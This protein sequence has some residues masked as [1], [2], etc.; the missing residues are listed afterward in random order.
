MEEYGGRDSA[1]LRDRLD[2]VRDIL[3]R[4]KFGFPPQR[5]KITAGPRAGKTAVQTSAG[6][7]IG[8]DLLPGKSLR[9]EARVV[10]PER[11]GRIPLAGDRLDC[12]VFS[13]FPFRMTCDGREILAC[14][15]PPIIRGRILAAVLDDLTPGQAHLVSVTIDVPDT[16]VAYGF[17]LAFS[18][19]RLRERWHEGDRAWARLLLASQSPSARGPVLDALAGRADEIFSATV[20]T[21]PDLISSLLP[22]RDHEPAQPF[23]VVHL[24]GHA[25]L[26]V[27]WLWSWDQAQRAALAVCSRAVDLLERAP[28]L[29]FSFSQPAV[30]AM[31]GEQDP[32]LLEAVREL[33][34]QGRWEPVTATWIEND[35]NVP[36]LESVAAQL[37]EGWRFTETE[38]GVRPEVCVAAD[39][40]GQPATLPGLLARAGCSAYFHTRCHPLPEHGGPAY[41]WAGLDG[42]EVIGLVADAY[43]GELLASRIAEAAVEARQAGL[44]DGLL[45]FDIDGYTGAD[46]VEALRR[47]SESAADPGLPPTRYSRLDNFAAAVA[48]QGLP[49]FS[50]VPPTIFE[51]TFS[52]Q[53]MV[54]QAN[55]RGEVLMQEAEALSCLAGADRRDALL[56]AS[57]RLL[58][59]Q[60]HDTLAG[61]AMASVYERLATDAAAWRHDVARI[62][63]S[64]AEWLSAGVDHDVAL[65]N[66]TPWR[67]RDW[68]VIDGSVAEAGR[69]IGTAVS[70]TGE[71]CP[72]QRGPAG[73]I[74][75]LADVPPWGVLGYDL[76][77]DDGTVDESRDEPLECSELRAA[78]VFVGEENR[79]EY[80]AVRNR[81]FSL[82]LRCDA[83]AVVSLVL[84]D[85]ERELVAYG[86]KRKT[87]FSNTARPELA[88]NVLQVV[89]ER[90]HS[91]SAWHL[92]EV[93]AE[94][95]LIHTG[96]TSCVEEGP[97]KVVLRTEHV[98]DQTTIRQDLTVYRDL[99]R[100]DVTVSVDW[101]ESCGNADGVASL[102]VAFTPDLPGARVHAAVVGGVV[103][104]PANGQERPMQRWV[105]V[106]D[107][108]HGV[109]ILTEDRYGFDALGP[110]VRV[111]LVRSAYDPVPDADAGEHVLRYSILPHPGTWR[112]ARL[113]VLAEEQGRPLLVRIPDRE[114]PALP[115]NPLPALAGS[116][117]GLLSTVRWA[118]AGDGVV[119]RIAEWSGTAG[120]MC[121]TGLPAD[122]ECWR[123]SLTEQPL[124]PLPVRDGR[125]DL[126]L[127]P[128]AVE[129]VLLRSMAFISRGAHASR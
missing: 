54:K 121:L 82:L 46:V 122:V 118:G 57:R 44:D 13:R 11:V 97:L 76:V 101:R 33:V 75:F 36:S 87:T 5:W 25:H 45:L 37:T 88:L 38:L 110:R 86:T 105:D 106:G 72:V 100:I 58:F 103:G 59:Q 56:R 79:K 127:A 74:G 53:V 30:Y 39:T 89:R 28:D 6:H 12:H 17:R 23:P 98:I 107:D 10:I 1:R 55:R 64:A 35:M 48:D 20:D 60:G 2:E 24:I 70:A 51:G 66:T 65:L 112:D 26:D 7:F 31:L 21:L 67:R 84:R 90:P 8:A 43:D 94:R 9:M 32:A 117:A 73:G 108:R 81:F 27:E 125:L 85:G 123:A 99:P 68:V 29:R 4:N 114:S 92:H 77:E 47:V 96:Q 40:F 109:A 83:G 69:K 119:C 120:K 42:S 34:R 61:T 49:T 3:G 71:R 14:E 62:R 16:L 116:G 91:M 19:P 80:F 129:T 113:P 102:K 93:S 78:E 126:H 128:W 104:H 115:R 95:S 18:T 15:D 50:G 52:S 22:L 41:R 124:G 111:T 63:D